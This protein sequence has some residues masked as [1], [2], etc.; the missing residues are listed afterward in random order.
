MKASPGPE[1]RVS[2]LLGLAQRA[3]KLA[4][5]EMAVK[6]ALAKGRGRLLL[7]AADA[8]PA[9][10]E[11][12]RLLAAGREL[13]WQQALSKELLGRAIGKG[14]RAMVLICDKNFARLIAA[15]LSQEGA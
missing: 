6:E 11:Q 9:K 12:A 13:P 14:E 10:A 8:A 5:G 4:S 15:A 7:V 3:G 2:A 1:A